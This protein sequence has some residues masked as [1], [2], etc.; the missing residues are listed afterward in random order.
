MY[1]GYFEH[2]L[3]DKGRLL[4]PKRMKEGLNESSSLYVLKGFEG[5]LSVYNEAEFNKLCLECE[6]ISFNHKNSRSYLRIVLGSVVQ[7]NLDK[8]GRIQLP[9]LILNKYN[10]KKDVIILGVGDHF[11][12]WDQEIYL[13]YEKATNDN[14]EE[15]AEK[16]EEENGK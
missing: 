2:T 7:L 9:N 12:I 3:D 4:L 10:I 16:M 6:K 13:A 15:I 1:F 14:F 11:E 5:C 8:V